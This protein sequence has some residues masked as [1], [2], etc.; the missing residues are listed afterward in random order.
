M[1]NPTLFYGLFG[2]LFF[3]LGRTTDLSAQ[4]GASLHHIQVATFADPQW[5][6]VKQLASL[7]YVFERKQANGL[8]R[9]VLGHFTDLAQARRVLQQVKNRGFKDALLQSRADKEQ[10]WLVQL[11]VYAAGDDIPWASWQN[12]FAPLCVQPLDGKLRLVLGP[13]ASQA[14]AA[15]AL[16]LAKARGVADAFVRTAGPSGVHTPTRL[17]M[18]RSPSFAALPLQRGSIKALQQLFSLDGALYKGQHH[19]VFDA[20]TQQAAQQYRAANLRFQNYQSFAQSPSYAGLYYR[21]KDYSLQYYINLIHQKPYTAEQGLKQ[22]KHPLAKAYLAYIYLTGLVPHPDAQN[23]VNRLMHQAL[24]EVAKVQS[25]SDADGFDFKVKYFY[26]NVGLLIQHLRPLHQKT[27]LPVDL[28]A[29]LYTKH[30]DL[31]VA[32][33]RPLE[34]AFNWSDDAGSFAN[35]PSLQ[36]LIIAARDMAQNPPSLPDWGKMNAAYW[37]VQPLS[38]QEGQAFEDWYLKRWTDLSV[39]GQKSVVQQ[40]IYNTVYFCFHD[41]LRELED[42]FLAKGLTAYDARLLGLRVLYFGVDAYLSRM[43]RS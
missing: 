14:Q 38:A 3:V 42:H 30:A 17:E 18:E 36:V 21:V 2:L 25:T 7:G 19:G 10:V 43:P 16:E 29:W 8:S 1:R 32:V 9:I 27:N 28:P 6:D 12:R 39:W 41:C 11:A 5:S 26:D 37:F 15:E 23:E 22:Q 4:S 34:D 24:A 35:L 31:A 20:P 40:S 13:F 33:F